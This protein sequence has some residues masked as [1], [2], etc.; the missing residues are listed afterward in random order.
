MQHYTY[1]SLKGG[2]ADEGED[3][4]FSANKS[5]SRNDAV[6]VRHRLEDALT[7][8]QL[9]NVSQSYIQCTDTLQT[10]ELSI[11]K[12]HP[13]GELYASSSHNQNVMAEEFTLEDEFEMDLKD[14]QMTFP[15]I[16]KDSLSGVLLACNFDVESAVDMLNQLEICPVDL[17]EKLPESLDIGDVPESVSYSKS[18]S[19]RDEALASTSVPFNLASDN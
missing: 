1:H 3:F 12:D 15:D 9:Q 10:A 16:S 14:L 11:L 6:W 17:S 19:Q 13:G 2:A 4:E 5:M 7:H 18:A 8:G